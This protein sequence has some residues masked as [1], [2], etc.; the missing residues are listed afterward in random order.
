MKTRNKQTARRIVIVGGGVAGL[1]ISIRLAQSGLPVTVLE[2]GHLG[3]A[4]STKN[5]GWLYSGAWF[6]PQQRDLARLCHQSLQET[7]NL[8]PECLEPACPSMT[9]IIS[10]HNTLPS[11]W[12]KAWNEAGIPY[13][14][15]GTQAAIDETGIPESLVQ[16]AYRLP[17][18][19]FR[20]DLLLECLTTKA[21]HLGV[22]VR[23]ESPVT[24]FIRTA[25]RVDGVVTLHGEEIAARLVI[26][27]AN[28]GGVPLWPDTAKPGEQTG[29]HRIG[30]KAN[31]LAVRPDFAGPFLRCRR[32]GIQ[33]HS[34]SKCFGVR[35]KPLGSDIWSSRRASD[36]A[37][38]RSPAEACFDLLSAF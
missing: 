18:R 24:A 8:C 7:I 30:L 11:H 23:T 15:I 29:F 33:P 25:D 9:F 17:D 21:E 26:L 13:Q 36:R 3:Q 10:S 27:A 31:C 1:S 34:A 12:T 32:R 4:A 37:R 6:A 28:L 14:Q 38:N 5:Q 16:H 2:A 19:A 22:E 35:L 20:S